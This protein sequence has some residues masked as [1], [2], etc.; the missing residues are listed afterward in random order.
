[1]SETSRSLSTDFRRMLAGSSS[2]IEALL[3]VL[4]HATFAI[5]WQSQRIEFGNPRMA[6][7]SNYTRG[8]L[9]GVH[10]SAL[11]SNWD[12]DILP[13]LASAALQK[14]ASITPYHPIAVDLIRRDQTK[15]PVHLVHL[16][17]PSRENIR[18][19]ALQP[20]DMHA[21]QQHQVTQ[22]SQFWNHLHMLVSA[23]LETDTQL[24][25][26]QA[27]E[28][29][30]QLCSA[31]AA[32]FYRADDHSPGPQSSAACGEAHR[33]PEQLPAQDLSSL[34]NPALW[35]TGKRPLT[36]LH[37]A[38]RAAQFAGI[39]SNPV[40]QSNALV[41]LV[42]LAYNSSAAPEHC[43]QMLP[44]LS[45]TIATILQNHSRAQQIDDE[46]Q[47][48]KVQ[49][50]AFQTAAENI[51][52]GLIFLNPDLQI[53]RINQAAEMI[54]GYAS[55][56]VKGQPVEHAVIGTESILPALA[57]A[58]Q[59][60]ST[61]HLGN[62]SLYRRNGE[63]F[64]AGV[65]VFPVLLDEQVNKIVIIIQDLSEQEQIR[66]QTQQLEQRAML[67]EVTA[68]FA[69]E[70]RNPINNISTGLQLMALNLPENDPNQETIER[71]MQD[72]DR[73]AELI[74]SVLTFSR[75]TEFEMAPVELPQLLKNLLE[76]LH[77]R[78]AR[79]NIQYSLQV[80]P[81]CP[82]ISGNLRALEQVFNNLINNALQA[83]N[84]NGGRLALRVQPVQSP[85]RSACVE[86]SVADTGPGIP[87]ELQERVFQPF[88]TTE[89]NGTGLGLAITKR[90]ITA[91]KGSI[92][93]NSFPGGTVFHIL[94][95][96][97]GSDS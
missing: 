84:E 29:A 12:K 79:L 14:E 26:H 92:R 3:E 91:H 60:S 20:V 78:I 48:I 57:S 73:L 39:A 38:A 81:G 23:V 32:V 35:A 27:L 8:E 15:I 37:R 87:K 34:R 46:M 89:R 70:V 33:M 52:E 24:A 75:P 96:A 49:L 55:R 51:Q 65:R 63:A 66:T 47:Q 44:L 2:D 58:L 42:V 83:M 94:F 25:L 19:I 6:E 61:Y 13:R 64:L 30:R 36:A 97:L 59:G 62:L 56:E 28:A 88:F 68:V 90:I 11:F 9:N 69:H 41:G 17:L 7:L 85:D 22:S 77:P 67:G 86:V 76:R 10:I 5:E 72:C 74:R 43:P 45:T 93:L 31:D 4:P 50:A 82:P 54:L 80:E 16:A 95:P 18:L 1:M 53:M 21:E 71:L 40:G